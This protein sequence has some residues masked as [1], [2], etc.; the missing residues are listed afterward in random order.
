MIKKGQF[1]AKIITPETNIKIR[2]KDVAG[3]DEAKVEITEFVDFLRSP[4]KYKDL[5]ARL[6]RGALLSGPPGTGKTMLAKVLYLYNY[7]IKKINRLVRGKRKSLSFTCQDQILL[8]C[9]LVLERLESEIYLNKRK[10]K[11]RL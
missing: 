4:K 8:K 3:L 2:F 6:P 7:R 10:K 1:K 5:G 11:L 9:L